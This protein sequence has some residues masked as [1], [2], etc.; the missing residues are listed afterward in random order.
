MPSGGDRRIEGRSDPFRAGSGQRPAFVGIVD[1]AFHRADELFQVVGFGQDQI[2]TVGEDRPDGADIGDQ[3]R[4]AECQPLEQ[5]QRE[6]FVAARHDEQIERDENGQLRGVGGAED[7]GMH[8]RQPVG[9]SQRLRLGHQPLRLGTLTAEEH[10]EVPSVL[11]EP[12]RRV[13]QQVETLAGDELPEGSHDRPVGRDPE[14]AS[15][16]L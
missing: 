9:Q 7:V 1:E 4:A 12:G 13:E 16:P 8:D 3:R 11:D 14:L 5:G 6:T 2:G 10:M 15:G